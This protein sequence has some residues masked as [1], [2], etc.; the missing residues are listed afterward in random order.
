MLVDHSLNHN[1][2]ACSFLCEPLAWDC[3]C[4]FRLEICK[5]QDILTYI[6][7]GERFWKV[8]FSNLFYGGMNII[9]D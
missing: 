1:L 6:E 5:F 9:S 3:S 8:V 4:H 7:I 2:G